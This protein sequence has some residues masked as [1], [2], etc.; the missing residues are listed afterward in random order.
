LSNRFTVAPCQSFYSKLDRLPYREKIF[1]YYFDYDLRILMKF[2]GRVQQPITHLL[3]EFDQNRAKIAKMYFSLEYSYVHWYS[4]A[5]FPDGFHCFFSTNIFVW[6]K[7]Y[8]INFV[9]N[10]KQWKENKIKKINENLKLKKLFVVYLN[11]HRIWTLYRKTSMVLI[12]YNSLEKPRRY[13]D[14]KKKPYFSV[15]VAAN[16]FRPSCPYVR[17]I[18]YSPQFLV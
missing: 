3:C 6:K 8:A 14:H 2:S 12:S 18:A 16:I 4:L 5:F 9:R 11:F 1:V 13:A 7:S 10:F 15:N 17:P